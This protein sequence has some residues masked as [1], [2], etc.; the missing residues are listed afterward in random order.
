MH[1][2]RSASTQRLGQPTEG[3]S[4]GGRPGVWTRRNCQPARAT[5]PDRPQ[6]PD[7]LEAKRPAR[8][9]STVHGR[10]PTGTGRGQVP[11]RRPTRVQ[12]PG[13]PELG[14]A[15][16]K[17]ERLGGT[18]VLRGPTAHSRHGAG[19]ARGTRHPD[20]HGSGRAAEAHSTAAPAGAA[21]SPTRTAC[22]DPTATG[23]GPGQAT[24]LPRTS[25]PGSVGQRPGTPHQ[26][27]TRMCS[28]LA[29]RGGRPRTM[30]GGT[31]SAPANS[32][33]TATARRR[34]PP[35]PR[36]QPGPT[37]HHSDPDSAS[38]WPA[39]PGKD[40]SGRSLRLG[41]KEPARP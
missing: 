8:L 19:H 4:T 28:N 35:V 5:Q 2:H 3:S 32:A 9:G 6:A 16:A 22:C 17:E 31:H 14:P 1:S 7:R 18:G 13:R 36:R 10:R 25:G 39:G 40:G 12:S 30:R 34:T 27:P 11:R 20:E 38:H 41:L 23:H 15:C 24:H 26:R 21:R 29:G 37:Q 33:D